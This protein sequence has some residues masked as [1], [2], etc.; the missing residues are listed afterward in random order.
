MEASMRNDRH[1]LKASGI[2]DVRSERDDLDSS[3]PQYEVAT[4]P[5]DFTLEGI[6]TKYKRQQI[7]I[8]GFQRKFVWSLRQS[9]KLIES[10]L[11]G[12]PVPA[13]FFFVNSDDR[14]YTVIDG[15]QRLLSIVHF[16]DGAFPSANGEQSRKF[17]LRG[18]HEQSPYRDKTY[19]NLKETDP[20]AFNTLNDSVLRA[21]VVRQLNPQD[22]TSAYHIFERLNTGGTHLVSQEI[23]NCIFSGP[24]N[25]LLSSLNGKSSW[26][27]VFGKQD[28]DKRQ[29]DVELVLRFLALRENSDQYRK[30]MKDFLSDFMNRHRYDDRGNIESFQTIFEKTMNA[31]SER[32]GEKPFHIKAGFNAAVFDAVSTAFSKHLDEIPEDISPRYASLVKNESFREMTS[33][34]TTDEDIISKRLHHAEEFLFG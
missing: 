14:K 23:R 26:R 29:R 6:V 4:Y 2:E 21:F 12:L 5:A 27:K 24:F 34:R 16:F 13:V 31:L 7:I 3:P 10:F 25:E 33:A 30:P 15:Q 11:L 22:T 1:H 19:E 9:T 17:A 32:L 8:P 28:P 18:L 20:A